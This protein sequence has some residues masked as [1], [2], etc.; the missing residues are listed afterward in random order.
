M[1]EAHGPMAQRISDDAQSRTNQISAL[2]TERISAKS[3]RFSPQLDWAK[4]D[5]PHDVN[6]EMPRLVEIGRPVMNMVKAKWGHRIS[7]VME[8]ECE[9]HGED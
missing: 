9:L 5:R 8:V 7:L 6:V 4:I 2:K 3:S 1:D